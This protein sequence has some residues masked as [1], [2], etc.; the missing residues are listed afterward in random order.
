V[1]GYYVHHQG[2][3][4]LHRMQCLARYL[5]TPVTVLTS[6]PRPQGYSGP[7]VEL[8]L[9]VGESQTVVDPTANGTVHWAP[10][11]GQGLRDRMAMIAQW[12]QQTRPTLMVVDVSCEV[13]R[14][15]RLMGVPVVVAAMRGDRQDRMHRDTYDMA[16]ALLAPW[17]ASAP[18]P[19][20]PEH[21]LT[22]TWHVGAF[23][24]ADDRPRLPRSLA[25]SGKRV[26]LLWG[27][28]GSD[29]D[30]GDVAAAR[31][32]TPGWDW[33]VMGLPGHAWIADSWPTLCGADVIVSHAGQNAI[34]EIAA[35]RRPAIVLPQQRPHGEQDA[36]AQALAR[37]GLATV[38]R[39]W[40]AAE[41]WPALLAGA[42]AGQLPQWEQWAPGDGAQRAAALIDAAAAGS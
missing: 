34:A 40:P 12:V 22:K 1:I 2:S 24:R 28:G 19:G 9:D 15:V 16:L 25:S 36:T 42:T 41:R 38:I 8:P 11:H 7:W 37:C 17:P 32:A 14:F 6:V 31:A 26:A 5:Q 23:S 35:A 20:W 29:V 33:D 4:H 30:T 10:V 27:S 3:G 18:E 21:W 39:D 13:A